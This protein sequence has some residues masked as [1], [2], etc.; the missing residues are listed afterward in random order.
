MALK[1]LKSKI[2]ATIRTNKV[3]K[4]M[5]AVSAVKMR[6]SQQRAFRARPYA[7]AALS[8]LARIS[9]SGEAFSH[10]LA[11][12]RAVKNTLT[13][14][15]TSDKGLAGSLNSSILKELERGLRS[16]GAD[17]DTQS[18]ICIGR[19]GYEYVLRQD[20]K[21]L[22][23]YLNMG[24][25]VTIQDMEEA[26]SLAIRAFESGGVDE[27]YV[28]YTNFR[29]TFQ[30]EP[31]LRKILPLQKGML[32]E[33][34]QGIVPEKGRFS[35]AKDASIVVPSYTIEPDATEVLEVLF[36]RLVAV[37][38]YHALLEA[39]ASEHSARMVAMKN[40]SD[41]SKE[42]VKDLSREYNGERQ[43]LITREVSEI[44]GGI[45]AMTH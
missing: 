20:Y 17:R 19:K 36:P 3:T 18:F 23:E 25:D 34:V 22:R 37:S 42:M 16:R 44:V 30:Q 33:M 14:V 1:Q 13:I 32:E 5:E 11:T 7:E 39:K 27:V 31:T 26:T 6:T 29:S 40:A 24:D 21:V 9:G 4:A 28:L 41:K 10:P 12:A 43:A 38:L 8:I 45:E 35:E 2:K 15:V